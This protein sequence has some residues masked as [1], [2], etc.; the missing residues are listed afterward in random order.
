MDERF[1]GFEKEVEDWHWWYRVRR[2]I[3]DRLLARLELDR[4]TARLL[5]V[6]CGTGGAALVLARYGHAIAVDR[7]AASFAISRDRPYRHRIVGDAGGPLPLADGSIDVVCALDILEHLDDDAAAARELARVT[8]PG[9]HVIAFVPAFNSLWD[10]NDEYSHHKRR[11][12]VGE[13]ER[14]LEQAGLEIVDSGYFNLVLFLPTLAA[15]VLQR[16]MPRALAGM[17]HGTRRTWLNEALRVVF[18]LEVPL[19]DR[20]RLPAGTSAYCV[21]R[22][23]A[24]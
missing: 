17:E 19:I 14:L 7:A 22:L 1:H 10:Y 5:D 16:A 6:G 23:S 9:G 3:L 2:D 20:V 24:A 8:R 18:S 13:L 15:R 11:Y 21:A 4:T 12:V